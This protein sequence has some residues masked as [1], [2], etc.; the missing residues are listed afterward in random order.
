MSTWI[1]GLSAPSSNSHMSSPHLSD[2]SPDEMLSL[3]LQKG[4]PALMFVTHLFKP[5]CSEHSLGCCHLSNKF[6]RKIF[7]EQG[8]EL[9][10]DHSDVKCVTIAGGYRM[11]G[12]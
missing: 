4:S 9:D 1:K 10:M 3:D 2:H 7:Q 5:T 12:Y 11:L 8:K 6:A